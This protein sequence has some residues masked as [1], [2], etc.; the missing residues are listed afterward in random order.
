MI[1]TNMTREEVEAE[2]IT[3]AGII[4]EK[5][6]SYLCMVQGDVV[7]EVPK[8][9]ISVSPSLTAYGYWESWVT[10][11]FTRNV[12]PKNKVLDV[13][14][15]CGYFSVIAASLGARVHAFEPLVDLANMIDNTAQIN[16]LD[17]KTWDY[18]LSDKND[19]VKIYTPENYVG[20]SSITADFKG[21]YETK[22]QW[23]ETKA[24]DR[25]PRAWALGVDLIKMDIEGAE[26][27]AWDGMG[28]VLRT[29]KPV[30]VLEYTSGRYSSNFPKK[31]GD[32]GNLSK[33]NHS[34]EEEFLFPEQLES[35]PE[36]EMVVVRPNV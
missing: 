21:Q 34:G 12:K 10:S 29:F 36:F 6:K 11:W 15:N 33:I 27:K 18:G 22:E 32:Y 17:I 30:V 7:M 2:G 5:P 16:G 23:I 26:E 14:A 24:L 19:D 20:S 8:N 3:T 31:L 13:G 9:D 4:R 1:R 25:F 28:H 35:F